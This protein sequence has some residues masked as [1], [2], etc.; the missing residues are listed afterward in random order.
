MSAINLIVFCCLLPWV[1]TVS[2]QGHPPLILPFHAAKDIEEGQKITLTC[3]VRKGSPPLEFSWTKDGR[4]LQSNP[5]LS[6]HNQEDFSFLTI[7][8]IQTA[9]RGNYA[10]QV[11]N[12]FGIGSH[13]TELLVN[14]KF[15]LVCL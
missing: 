1:E 11:K 6:F 12:K 3:S 15:T 14:C 4:K 5:N 8:N 9:D 2:N 13:A 10:C 7:K